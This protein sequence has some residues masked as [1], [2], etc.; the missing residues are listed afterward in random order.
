MSGFFTV[1]PFAKAH[2]SAE[3]FTQGLA[4]AHVFQQLLEEM[5]ELENFIK[6]NNDEKETAIAKIVYQQLEEQ[7]AIM[8]SPNGT[9]NAAE[10]SGN[11][12]SSSLP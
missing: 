6:E 8:I 3:K 11:I 2:K 1:G 9:Q 10:R 12:S 5:E 4:R 7:L